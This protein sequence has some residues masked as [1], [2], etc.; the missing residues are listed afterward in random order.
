MTP[1]GHGFDERALDAVQR[2]TFEPARQNGHPIPARIRYRY[3]FELRE[4]TPPAR[5]HPEENVAPPTGRLEGR[6]LSRE[7]GNPVRDAEVLVTSSENEINRRV[8]A[9]RRGRFVVDELPPGTYHVRIYAN[10]YGQYEADEEVVSNEVTDVTYR[11]ELLRDPNEFG[12]TA[13]R[14]ARR[15]RSSA[16]DLA[17][18]ADAR[19]RHA[20]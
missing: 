19:R 8:V 2:F 7:D 17:R 3:V 20:R 12:A 15:A 16:H 1:A 11:I 14:R 5:E 18:G 10:E 13:H 6:V 4:A 9:N